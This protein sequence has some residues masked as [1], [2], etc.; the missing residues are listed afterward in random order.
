MACIGKASRC[1]L[2]LRLQFA[3][4]KY[5]SSSKS[6]TRLPRQARLTS[7]KSA[8]AAL[9]VASLFGDSTPPSSVANGIGTES[10]ETRRIYVGGE[11]RASAAWFG[12]ATAAYL[13]ERWDEADNIA[14][15]LRR[16]ISEAEYTF[17][18]E[19]APAGVVVPVDVDQGAPVDAR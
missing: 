14:K 11:K 13:F 2:S 17:R 15:R 16:R 9:S 3:R 8:A 7:A 10:G 5:P 6:I 4:A 12:P 19:E 1:R 18:A